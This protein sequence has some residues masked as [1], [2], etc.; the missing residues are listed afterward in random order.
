[1]SVILLIASRWQALLADLKRRKVF[2]RCRDVW[3][4]RICH[5]SHRLSPLV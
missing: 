2:R 3:R 1:M 4:G 5:A